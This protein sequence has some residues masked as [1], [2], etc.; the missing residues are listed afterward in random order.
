M[1][2]LHDA[3]RSRKLVAVLR[4]PDAN[5]FV[6][7]SN[8]LYD[9]GFRCLEF[10][11]TTDGA[12][13]ALRNARKALPDDVLLGIGTVRTLAQVDAALEAGADFLVSQTFN[14][15]VVDSAQSRGVPFIPGTLTPNE[16]VA[17]WEHGVPAVKVS[18]IG[19]VGG[20]E[21]LTE[22]AAPLPEVPI[23]PTGG[24]TVDNG[25]EYLRRGAIA[26]GISRSLTGDALVPG[27]DLDALAERAR[28]AVAGV[29]ATAA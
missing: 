24:V 9:A 18:P 11:L 6:A 10:T 7:V 25:P 29:A 23:M 16:V 8:V 1:I 21:Y 12:L 27:G 28:T 4:A 14:A 15:A 3:L 5:R 20:P 22:L 19:P 2:D 26:V 13:D 17:A